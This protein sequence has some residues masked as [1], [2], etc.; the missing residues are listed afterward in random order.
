MKWLRRAIFPLVIFCIFFLFTS[1]ANAIEVRPYSGHVNDFAQV[2]STDATAEIESKLLAESQRSDGVEVVVVTLQSL[3]GEVI[4]SVALQ[5]FDEWKIGKKDF[6]NGVLFI[7]AIDD[8]EIRIQT[9]YGVEG[10]L[11]DGMAGRIIRNDIIPYLQRD[12]YDGAIN[13]GVDKIL[14]ATVA[15]EGASL[16]GAASTNVASPLFVLLIMVFFVGGIILFILLIAK[17]AKKTGSHGHRSSTPTTL[18]PSSRSS[19]SSSKSFSFG[20]GRSGGG[21]A[22]GKW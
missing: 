22:S 7:L 15:P 12:D 18:K 20:G 16:E 19:S 10:D 4:E 13:A 5:Y 1:S 14:Q 21:G 3:E 2:L 6:D 17:L 8:R 11:P 9:G